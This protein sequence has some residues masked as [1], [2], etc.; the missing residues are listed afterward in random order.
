MS[1]KVRTQK[2]VNEKYDKKRKLKKKP[3]EK[4]VSI[5]NIKFSS[6]NNKF[7]ISRNRMVLTPQYKEFKT[8]VYVAAKAVKDIK[9]PYK[10]IIVMHTSMDIDNSIKC[11]IDALEDKKIL[12][13]DKHIE[14][15]IVKKTPKKKN[16]EGLLEVYLGS[17]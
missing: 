7:F 2:D 12:I 1:I 16:E 8:I 14:R 6:I 5:S 15:L 10:M 4:I 11:I 3:Y 13:N 17:L 9:P